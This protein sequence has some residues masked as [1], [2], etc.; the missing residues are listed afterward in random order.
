MS[1]PL[2]E[3]SAT[4]VYGWSLWKTEESTPSSI[5]LPL[6]RTSL[7][8]SGPSE[9]AVLS[10]LERIVPAADPAPQPT[11]LERMRKLASMATLGVRATAPPEEDRDM[12]LAPLTT[13]D[14]LHG[15]EKL[16]RAEERD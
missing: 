10:I 3:D 1:Q 2:K 9:A 15:V 6:I 14:A 8:R 13:G 7:K 5:G 4:H 12:K 11:A 16:R